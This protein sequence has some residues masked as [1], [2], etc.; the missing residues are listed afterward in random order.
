MDTK[1]DHYFYVLYCQ[2]GTLYGGYTVD[3]AN[4]LKTHNEGKGAKYTRVKKRQPVQMIYAERY[5]SKSLAMSQ[6]AKFKR[7]SRQAKENYLKAN[8]QDD[9]R[10]HQ[11]VL[12]NKAHEEITEEEQINH[13]T[14]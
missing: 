8:G 3:L 12:V 9:V 7:L 2:D 14:T 4:R 11:L 10:S 13:A 5:Y 1:Q 6:E